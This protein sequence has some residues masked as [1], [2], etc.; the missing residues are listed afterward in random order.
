MSNN[1]FSGFFNDPD[2]EHLHSGNFA[3]CVRESEAPLFISFCSSESRDFDSRID[4][5]N[6]KFSQFMVVY[7][8]A[9]MRSLAGPGPSRR[10]EVRNPEKLYRLGVLNLDEVPSFGQALSQ[11]LGINSANTPAIGAFYKGKLVGCASW[12]DNWDRLRQD[13]LAVL[14]TPQLP[15]FD[16]TLPQ[17]WDSPNVSYHRQ[18]IRE[19]NL[20]SVHGVD[21][22][23]LFGFTIGLFHLYKHPEIMIAYPN[24]DSLPKILNYMMNEVSKGQRF[25]VNRRYGGVIKMSDSRPLD[26]GFTKMNNVQI[27]EF[28]G[29]AISFYAGE[30]FPA[31]M[32]CWPDGQN[33]LPSQVGCDPAVVKLQYC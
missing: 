25:D 29:T 13:S 17:S 15:I 24:Q 7:V 28:L 26:V 30:P 19:N 20:P 21:T 23:P 33:R 14:N 6:T 9:A 16:P 10:I 31:L 27:K 2:L 8:A 4:I 1:R 22:T 12:S 18:F 11:K 3:S 32:C 5:F